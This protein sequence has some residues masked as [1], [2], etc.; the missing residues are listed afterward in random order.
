MRE[1]LIKSPFGFLAI[2]TNPDYIQGRRKG[3]C[4]KQM[5]YMLYERSITTADQ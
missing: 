3:S 1:V 4:L 2:Y 5:S